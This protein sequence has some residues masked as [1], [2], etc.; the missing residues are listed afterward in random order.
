MRR[1]VA[2]ATPLLVT[3]SDC[4]S[5]VD[6]ILGVVMDELDVPAVVMFELVRAEA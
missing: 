5:D 1:M 4:G 3:L 6:R 2:A